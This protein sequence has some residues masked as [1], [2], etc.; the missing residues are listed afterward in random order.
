MAIVHEDLITLEIIN[1]ITGRSSAAWRLAR[2]LK[3]QAA[4]D[5]HRAI[6]EG[7]GGYVDGYSRDVT[8]IQNRS[9][10][11]AVSSI[12]CHCFSDG[13]RPETARVEDIDLTALGGF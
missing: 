4:E 13:D 1:A 12:D 3:V 10:T 2:T 6:H 8:R 9:K 5:D 11:V 7:A